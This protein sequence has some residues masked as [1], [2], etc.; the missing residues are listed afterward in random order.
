MSADH[1][2]PSIFAEFA[3]LPDTAAAANI[4]FLIFPTPQ[5]EGLNTCNSDESP[6]LAS[7]CD[8]TAAANVDFLIFPTPQNGNGET[9]KQENHFSSSAER[10]DSRRREAWDSAPLAR[11]PLSSFAGPRRA[12]TNLQNLA[13]KRQSSRHSLKRVA[14]RRC[15]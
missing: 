3:S 9:E 6:V 11:A 4:D 13:P 14:G 1:A 10:R 5:A 8:E 2:D 15:W 12:G 7:P